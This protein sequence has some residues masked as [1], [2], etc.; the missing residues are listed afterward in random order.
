VG[1]IPRVAF[2]TDTF[3]EIN[4]VAL[5]SRQLTGFAGQREYPLLCVRGGEVSRASSAGSV[6]HVELARGPLAFELDHA[7]HHDPFLWRHGA[8]VSKVLR[9]FRPDIFH[10]VSP[11]DVSEMGV[12]FAR[13][14]NIPLAVSWH[15]NLHEF[16]AMRIAR[17][18]SRAPDALRKGVARVSEARILD[19]LV[20]FYRLGKVLYAPNNELVELL[21]TRTGKPVFLMKR[22][23]DTNFFTP[24]KRAVSD[25]VLRLGYVGRITPE[26]SV[27]F[28]QQLE[29]ALLA[30]DVPKFRIT[31]IGDGSE[32]DWLSKNLRNGDLPG[33]QRGETL[34]RS[35]ADMDVFVFPSRTDTFG[36]VVLEAFASGVPA[37]VTD[38]G[39][40]KFIV[41]EGVS[42][43]VARSEAEFIEYTAR[44]LTDAALRR[45]M[46]QAARDQA[47]SESWEAVFEKV[48]AGY[49]VALGW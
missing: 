5:T 19:V 49:A 29:S 46:G 33:I 36:N 4:G 8:Y 17:A 14:M 34:A 23:I 28:L 7:L 16:G 45:L 20:A 10:V 2:F 18:L 43:F 25:S 32:K 39:G 30:R 1:R 11:G 15:T 48:Y 24:E 22:G 42:G 38:A 35:Y 12:W 21:Q 41:N 26:K 13:R 3:Q 31:V 9:E 40:P 27:R 37:V 6:T 44:L 47:R